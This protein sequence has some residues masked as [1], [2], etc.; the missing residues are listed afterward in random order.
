[1]GDHVAFCLGHA[2]QIFILSI[3]K[4]HLYIYSSDLPVFLWGIATSGTA[5]GK[6][7]PAR[8][9]HFQNAGRGYYPRKKLS[10]Q[11]GAS[12]QMQ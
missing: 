8:T 4:M 1:M 5:K 6:K 7:A 11:A 10:C 3:T 9:T 12:L 2:I